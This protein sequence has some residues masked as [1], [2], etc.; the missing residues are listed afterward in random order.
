MNPLRRY[1]RSLL[2]EETQQQ[3][4]GIAGAGVVFVCQEDGTVFLQHRADDVMGGAGQWG[5]PGGGIHVEGQREQKWPVPIPKEHVLADDS[6]RFYKQA[7]E[8]VREECGSVPKSR[9]IDTYLYEDRGF[10][11][12]TFVATVAKT[13]KD[14]WDPAPAAGFE[15]ETKGERWFT[16]KQFEAADLFFG[17]TPE[18]IAKVKNAAAKPSLKE[19][20]RTFIKRTVDD[21]YYQ[22]RENFG[23]FTTFET[24]DDA[25]RKKK[26]RHIKTDWKEEA[27]H[28]FFASLIKVHWLDTDRAKSP[29]H[30]IDRAMNNGRNKDEISVALYSPTRNI[31]SKWGP[32]G[33]QIQGR[34]TLASNDMDSLFT[35]YG[36]LKKS[37]R[38]SFKSS[39][40]PK[41]PS[42]A[43]KYSME[44][45]ILDARSF[46]NTSRN[47]GIIANWELVSIRISVDFFDAAEAVQQHLLDFCEEVG[48]KVYAPNGDIV[49][50]AEPPQW[51]V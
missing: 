47:E 48:L 45:Y 19:D 12:K 39:G 10:K 22:S 38:A 37:V 43:S 3:Y 11:Y 42:K 34:T 21:N 32:V 23:E 7:I 33:L 51:E 14:E 29:M 18:L 2:L 25:Y 36:N 40:V 15:H 6:K 16:V 26:I 24:P 8:E 31:H 35:G 17:F 9:V 20:L 44:K 4:W 28:A 49:T 1:V 41:R 27:D 13:E 46:K 5:F 50:E 30:I